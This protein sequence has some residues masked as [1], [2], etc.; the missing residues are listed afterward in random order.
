MRSA[1]TPA[2]VL[3][4]TVRTCPLLPLAVCSSHIAHF[5]TFLIVDSKTQVSAIEVAPTSFTEHK[6][7]AILLIGHHVRDI[8]S[9]QIL[10]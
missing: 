3:S 9:Y 6:D 4:L 7:I 10:C 8:Y 2:I 1:P 5:R